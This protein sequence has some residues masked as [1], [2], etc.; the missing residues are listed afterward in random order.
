MKNFIKIFLAVVVLVVVGVLLAPLVIINFGSEYSATT[1]KLILS[2]VTDYAEDTPEQG[3]LDERLKLPPGFSYSIYASN[4]GKLRFMRFTAAGDLLVARPKTGEILILHKDLD[5]DK[6]PDGQ[7]TLIANL[8]R[9]HSMDF[10]GDWLYIAESN[11]VGRVKYDAANKQ[12]VSEYERVVEGL[13]DDGNHW[14][15]TIRV[16]PDGWIYLSSGSTCNVCEEEDPQRASIMRFKPD[17]SGLEIF[18]SGL[19]NSVGLDFA[20]W[21][22]SLYATDNGRDM[23][24]DDFPPCELNRIVK[25]GFYGWPYIN[26]FADLDPD[27]GGGKDELLNTSIS[28]A[29]GFRAHNAPLGI[30]FIRNT[31]LP[32]I[33][34]KSALVALHGSWN[35]SERDGYKIVSLHWL[36]D[37]T[38]EERDFFTGFLGK[39][40]VLARL[41]DVKEGPDGAFYISEDYTGAIFRVAYE[42][43]SIRQSLKELA[44]QQA[45]EQVE[46]E[47]L[48]SEGELKNFNAQG[49]VLFNQY[50][51]ANCHNDRFKDRRN[52]KG[53]QQRYSVDALSAFFITPT[54][55]MPRF[56]LDEQQ[57]KALAIYLYQNK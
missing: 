40:D 43:Q 32:E 10:Y 46:L 1:V 47:A 28:P 35:R 2:A 45:Q 5:G 9:P 44:A 56:D 26:G 7:A 52:L 57:R 31:D 13:G 11:A 48:F 14:T 36:D 53:I 3:V 23:L 25:D 12:L 19:R 18:A 15:K 55:P 50:G 49:E 24:G 41:V 6:K 8:V 39:G 37:G 4:L 54:P 17:G 20:P 30:H 42:E 21:D 27:M 29:H 22:Q 38:I 51:C 34:R 16:G 33:Y